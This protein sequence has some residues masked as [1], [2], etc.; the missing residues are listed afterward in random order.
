M[1]YSFID[2]DKH[3]NDI[4]DQMLHTVVH[5]PSLI[6]EVNDNKIKGE[7]AIPGFKKDELSIRAHPKYIDISGKMETSRYRRIR[8]SFH[9]KIN[10]PQR[11]DPD[12]VKISLGDGM[13]LFEVNIE[14]GKEVKIIDF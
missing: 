3:M 2:I 13:L 12:T 11:V 9:R 5:D 1:K 4:R 14:R 8:D 7:L 10:F 6:F